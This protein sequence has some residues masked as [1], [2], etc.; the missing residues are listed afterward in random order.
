[1]IS[2]IASVLNPLLTAKK[3][4]ISIIMAATMV[5]S[6]NGMIASSPNPPKYEIVITMNIRAMS[7]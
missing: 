6:G 2:S 3:W 5:S 4:N 1:M 7:Q